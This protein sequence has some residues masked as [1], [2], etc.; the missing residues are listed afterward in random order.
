MVANPDADT[1]SAPAAATGGARAAATSCGRG[2]HLYPRRGASK[3]RQLRRSRWARP[4]IWRLTGSPYHQLQVM[5]LLRETARRGATVVVVLHDLTLAARFCDRLVL[6]DMGCVVADGAP[7]AVFTAAHL[8]RVYRISVLRDPH[9]CTLYVVPW[10][11]QPD[12]AVPS[13]CGRA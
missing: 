4:N 2:S 11:R 3:K 12:P 10:T 13:P 6:L 8:R 1:V 5:K 9:D 7:E